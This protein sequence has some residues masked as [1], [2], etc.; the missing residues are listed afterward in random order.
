MNVTDYST[1]Y[2]IAN[3]IANTTGND[4]GNASTSTCG[5]FN[6]LDCAPNEINGQERFLAILIVALACAILTLSI[7]IFILGVIVQRL[8]IIW[9][10]ALTKPIET[11]G[12]E[13]RKGL[14]QSVKKSLVPKPKKETRFAVNTSCA[15]ARDVD[16]EDL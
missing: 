1:A 15:P 14:L 7:L 10:K 11:E 16:E 12:T 8:S 2:A 9:M 5:I 13:A 3:T 6:Y 4:T